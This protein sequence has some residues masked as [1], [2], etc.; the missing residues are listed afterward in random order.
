LLSISHIGF[1]LQN[2]FPFETLKLKCCKFSFIEIVVEKDNFEIN[3]RRIS[4][5][6]NKVSYSS[7][8]V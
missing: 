4:V 6:D 2:F 7:Q 1:G 5:T 8:S 3:F